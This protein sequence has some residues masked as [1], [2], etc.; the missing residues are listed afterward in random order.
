MRLQ[1]ADSGRPSKVV[2]VYS[3]RKQELSAGGGLASILEAAKK[4]VTNPQI[5]KAAGS[6][7]GGLIKKKSAPAPGQVPASIPTGQA[8]DFVNVITGAENTIN[9][10]KAN[11]ERLLAAQSSL[12]T[13]RYIF[14][15][16]GLATGLGLGFVL[17]R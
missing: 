5:Q 12:K 9:E 15:A 17:K 10:L 14:G 2:R 7:I 16:V 3:Q 11:N 8:V 6:V 1:L 4:V 13:Q